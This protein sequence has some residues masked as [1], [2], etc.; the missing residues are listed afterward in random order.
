MKKVWIGLA[1]LAAFL[2][3]LV[4]AAPSAQAA[5]DGSITN[6]SR[7]D[8]SLCLYYLMNAGGSHVGLVGTVYNY[9]Q[10]PAQCGSSGCAPYYFQS[11]GGGQGQH[12][13]NDAEFA[14]NYSGNVYRV[15]YNSGFGGPADELDPLGYG[16]YFRNLNQ[17]YN[18]NAS[19][20][21]MCGEC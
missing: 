7:Y 21:Y 20:Q 8:G 2:V 13:K 10:N 11:D 16:T 5:A 17:T 1:A 18:N 14:Y 3:P 4:G 9:D 6:C 15:Y 12:V 19:Q